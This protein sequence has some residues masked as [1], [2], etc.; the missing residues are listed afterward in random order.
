MSIMSVNVKMAKVGIAFG[1]IVFVTVGALA[2]DSA[3]MLPGEDGTKSAIS[4]APFPD[5][6]SAYIW[7]N[8]GLVPVAKLAEV[9]GAT[10]AE[11]NAVAADMGLRADPVV[12][13]EWRTKGYITVLRR[14]WH[15]LPYDQLLTLLGKTRDE[16]YFS[17]M[18]DDFLWVKLGSLKPKC[19]A[20]RWRAEM[21]ESGKGERERI[22]AIL[23]EEGLDP[24]APE[25]PRFTFVKEIASVAPGSNNRTIEQLNNSDSPFDFRVI[26]S[27]FADY[28]DPLADPEVGSFPEGLLQKLSA[29]GVNAVWMHTVLRTLAK[30]PK[31]PEFGAGSEKRIANLR[32]LVARAQKYG[33]RVFLYMNEPRAQPAEFF[34]AQPWRT[35]MKGASDGVQ[36]A[37]CTSNPETLRW[38][39]DSLEQVFSSVPGLGGIFTIT[40]SENLT[41]CDARWH[42][43]RCP[44]C[45]KRT[46]AELVVETNRAMIEGMRRGNPK[47]EAILYSWAWPEKDQAAIVAGLPQEGCRVLC[48]SEHGMRICRGG[49]PAKEEDY[50][51]SIVGPGEESTALWKLARTRGIPCMAKVQAANSWELSSF[52]YVPAMDLVARHASNLAN[53][54]VNGVMLSWSLGCCPSP[55]LSVYRDLRKDEKTPDGVLDRLAER[56]YGRTN[57]ARVRQAWKAFSDGFANYPFACQVIYNGPHQWG[58]ANPLY[59]APTG[60]EATMVG[61]PY[62]DLKGWRAQYPGETYAMLMDRVADG[63]DEGCRLLEGVADAKELAMFRAEQMHFASCRDQARFV[64]AREAGDVGGMRRY[65]KA[66]LERAKAYWPI[67]RADSRIG[68]ESSNHYFFVP[69]DV[70]EKVLSCRMVLDR[71]AAAEGGLAPRFS[72]AGYWEVGD[73]PRRT[74]SLNADWEFSL[75]G[76]AT[77]RRVALPHCIDEGEIGFA[78]SGCVNRQQPV[79]YR[80]RFEW[81]RRSDRAFLHFEAIMGKS[82][83]RVNGRQVAEHFGGFLPIHV[84][85]TDVL[86]NG[87]NEVEVWCDNSDDGS[88]PPGKP[89]RALDFTYFGGIYRDVWLVETGAAYVTDPANGGVYVTSHLEQDGSW[90]VRADV[91]VDG[92]SD[93]SS[94]R[95]LYDGEEVVSPFKPKDPALWSPASPNLHMLRV[96]VV[97]DGRTLDAVGV[98]FGIRDFRIGADGFVLNGRPYPR[99]LIGTNRHQ[100]YLF[101]GMAMP[102]SLHWRDVKKYRDC[103]LEMVRNAHYPQDPAFMDACDELGMFVIVNTPGWQ[104]WNAGDP[105]FEKRVY[106][107]IRG[108]VRRDRSRPSLL[109]W[110]P[111]LNEASFP[112][113]FATNALALVKRETRAPNFCACD[114]ISAGSGFFDVNYACSGERRDK[115]MFTREW[116]DFP[117]DWNAQNS[118]SRAAREWGETPM[119][120]QAWHYL[121]ETYWPSLATERAKD[122]NH[123]GGALWHGADHARGFHPDNFFGGILT[124]GRQKKYSYYALKAAL[125]EKPFVFLAH[126]LAAGSPAEMTVYA[127]C[128]YRATWLGRP[129]EPGKT[130]FAW[131]DVQAMTYETAAH[132]ATDAVFRVE[133][134]DGTAWERRR[135]KRMAQILV[136][137]DTEGLAPVADGSDLV[138]VTATLA[139]ADGTPKRY[140][141]E[142]IRFAVDGPAEIVGENPQ[143]TRWGEAI[144]LLRPKKTAEPRPITVSASLVR[145]GSLVRQ[146]GALTFTPGSAKTAFRGGFSGYDEAIRE[147]E[148]QQRDY[149]FKGNQP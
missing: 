65:A 16:L 17:L 124:Y 148:R 46:T 82:R 10:P 114:D 136:A 50:S 147:V 140:A 7:R 15:L 42:K 135:A 87:L 53:A 129:F 61:I 78:A 86:T 45:C 83:I 105:N 20:L 145:T 68:Y 121:H 26:F 22:A 48:V 128:P 79:W 36:F 94:V 131:A 67:V 62:D 3:T 75:D 60:Y 37:M 8:W 41:H 40:M 56:L 111:I 126:E 139:D 33:I 85:V 76:F 19:E 51:I 137:L 28:A 127:N 30:D 2:R 99:K 69:R 116:G 66:E 108:M 142:R 21:R 112:E 55:N 106:E 146:G 123:F 88:Y 38:L 12:L 81:S 98:R 18:E 1:C 134:P 27:Y 133:L 58:P 39:S 144:V 14:N 113:P 130:R 70:L 6:M 13:P 80:R 52:P 90:T 93:G 43:D 101:I 11:L 47:A 109:M 72:K 29:Q 149:N 74:T 5:R 73:S 97:K 115:A 57:V 122:A 71:S 103:G 23:K 64:M 102:N 117:D 143:E 9:V 110:E 132:V 31:Y 84:E 49:V 34:A 118:S 92:E 89:Q 95:L 24:N 119:V 63:F 107:D 32:K 138:A 59:A 4:P 100:D 91:T 96:E 141:R 44:R 77:S 125:T 104:F 120:A 35:A 25:E 54:G